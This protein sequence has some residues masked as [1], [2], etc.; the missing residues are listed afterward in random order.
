MVLKDPD[1]GPE[2]FLNPNWIQCVFA[3][4]FMLLCIYLVLNL[5]LAIVCDIYS[6]RKGALER[7]R[8]AGRRRSLERAFALLRTAAAAAEDHDGQLQP[9]PATISDDDDKKDSGQSSSSNVAVPTYVVQAV[10]ELV[11]AFA[12]SAPRLTRRGIAAVVEDLDP[13][14]AGVVS[15][16][17]FMRLPELL[18]SPHGRQQ[19]LGEASSPRPASGGGGDAKEADGEE[20]EEEKVGKEQEQQLQQQG[21]TQRR[22]RF[23]DLWCPRMAR[24]GAFHRFERF[25]KG[26]VLEGFIDVVILANVALALAAH[27]GENKASGSEDQRPGRAFLS[28][29]GFTYVAALIFSCECLSKLLVL[30]WRRYVASYMNVFDAVLTL[31]TVLGAIYELGGFRDSA[32]HH[33]LLVFELLRVLRLFRALLSI[34]TFRATALTF[35]KILPSASALLLNLFALTFAFAVVGLEAYGGLINKGVC[36]WVVC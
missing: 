28:Q 11:G 34:P 5:G 12:S 25:V 35:A 15:Q 30:G 36:P 2:D 17:A 32:Q 10:L 20:E 9:P 18:F 19:H 24:S 33:A 27:G 7:Q 26:P 21:Y 8:E 23:V 31:L 29:S 14:R 13:K 3:F 1:G 4:S 22:P 6:E 16:D